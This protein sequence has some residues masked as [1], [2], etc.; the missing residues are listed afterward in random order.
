MTSV[1]TPATTKA[2]WA[3]LLSIRPEAGPGDRLLISDPRTRRR[4]F[5]DAETLADLLLAEETGTAAPVAAGRLRDALTQRGWLGTA[6]Q[7][8]TSTER[9]WLDRQWHPSLEYYLW[10]RRPDFADT[11][12][13]DGSVRTGLVEG[14]LSDGPPDSFAEQPR[15]DVTL[16][17]PRAL[18]AGLPL[19][20]VLLARR[21]TRSFTAAPTTVQDLSD[22]LWHAFDD[23]RRVRAIP[24]TGPL[25][26]FRS[27][28]SAFDFY[29]VVYGVGDIPPG[30]YRYHLAAHQLDLVTPGEHREEMVQTILGMRGPYTAACT[31]SI[32][33]DFPRYQWRYRHE[34]A[35]RHLYMAAG[36]L[37]QR[38][39]IVGESLGL[40][41]LPTPATRDR[42]FAALHRLDERRQAPMYTFTMGRVQDRR[43]PATSGP[44]GPVSSD[45][46]V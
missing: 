38:L 27:H 11:F 2:V 9:K 34:R 22:I 24:V 46:S 7:G 31:V 12:D 45:R 40:G 10:S 8:E 1:T 28:G 25:D 19:T 3:D 26:Y 44:A 35:L 14:Y 41:T 36:R 13:A 20:S 5:V 43:R 4:S 42:R 16:P 33:V 15:G 23:V 17:A 6:D 37:G 32:I 18:P 21:S 39:I 30:V 29:T